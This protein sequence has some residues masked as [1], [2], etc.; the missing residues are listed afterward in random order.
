MSKSFRTAVKAAIAKALPDSARWDVVGNL[1]KIDTWRKQY[2]GKNCPIFDQR[3][4]LYDYLLVDVLQRRPI[5]YLEFGVYKGESIAY[6][7]QHDQNAESRF[8]GFDTFTGLPEDWQK[9]SGDMAKDVFDC[10]GAAPPLA[11]SRVQFVKGLFQDSLD[12]FLK[13]FTPRGQ[14]V[15]HN[16]SDLYSSTL[17]VLTRCHDLLTPGAIVVFDEFS[18]VLNEFMALKN[19]C[20]AYRRDYEVLGATSEYFAQVAIRFR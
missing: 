1:P 19:Y 13:T 10:G 7:S 9:F 17:Y 14:L 8:F 2:V 20:S 5:D 6:W 12:P 11:D 4:Q 15:L 3:E 18:S 16:D